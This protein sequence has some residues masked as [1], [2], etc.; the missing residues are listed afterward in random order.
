M[1]KVGQGQL[2]HFISANFYLIMCENNTKIMIILFCLIS[3][4][5]EVYVTIMQDLLLLV[6]FL[7][8]PIR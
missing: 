5:I 2:M 4:I 7:G 8:L 6:G 1:D 3:T